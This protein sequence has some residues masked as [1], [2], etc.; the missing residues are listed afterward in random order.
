MI[1]CAKK[2]IRYLCH[3]RAVSALEYAMIVGVIAVA[4]AAALAAFSPNI[5][6]VLTQIGGQVESTQGGSIGSLN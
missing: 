1:R 3:T 5:T 6:T 2:F 4:I